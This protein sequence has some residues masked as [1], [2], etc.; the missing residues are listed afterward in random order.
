M[1]EQRSEMYQQFEIERERWDQEKKKN[2]Q[3]LQQVKYS[4]QFLLWC[5]IFILKYNPLFKLCTKKATAH[6]NTGNE[7]M[8]TCEYIKNCY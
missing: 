3:Q 4:I 6:S 8:P 5:K 1:E 7:V 2:C